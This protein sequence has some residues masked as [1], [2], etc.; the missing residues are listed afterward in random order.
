MRS[1]GLRHRRRISRASAAALVTALA[2]TSLASCGTSSS[3]DDDSS[4]AS[5]GSSDPSAPLDPKTK[6]TISIDCMPPAAKAA[7]L[8]EWKHAGF[9]ATAAPWLP[10][11]DGW[12]DYAADLQDGDPDSMLS[13]YREA[14][15]L[16][17]GEPGFGTAGEPGVRRLTWL[18][19]APEVLAFARTDGLVCVVNLADKAAELPPYTKILLASGPLDPA[20]RLPRDT[21]RLRT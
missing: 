2:L 6:V 1:A 20:G 9:G 3:K 17:R 15:R 12:P 21:V 4:S 10:Q 8:R 18:D 7:E 5:K 16:R 19:T 13:L 11:P 14:L